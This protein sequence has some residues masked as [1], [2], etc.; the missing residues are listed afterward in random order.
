MTNAAREVPIA[1]LEDQLR[2]YDNKSQVNHRLYTAGTIALLVVGAAVPVCAW[3][4][5]PL[6]VALLGAAIVVISG[7]ASIFQW[8]YHWINYR[9]TAE[10][11]KHEKYLFEAQA[12]P[13]VL[14]SDEERLRSLAE[15]VEGVVSREHSA[16]VTVQEEKLRR[17]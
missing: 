6:I 11:L 9:A 13:Y 15:R 17:P 8:Q 14:E 3:I 7:S 16:W 5:P 4:A 12:G 10:R 1:R 2:W